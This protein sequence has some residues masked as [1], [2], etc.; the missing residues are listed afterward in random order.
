M[1]FPGNKEAEGAFKAL[2]ASFLAGVCQLLCVCVLLNE[3][4]SMVLVQDLADA[5]VAAQ[6]KRAAPVFAGGLLDV[7]RPIKQGWKAV[8][9]CR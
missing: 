5:D 3:T 6:L 4:S 9:L 7:N 8:L 2:A 1:A